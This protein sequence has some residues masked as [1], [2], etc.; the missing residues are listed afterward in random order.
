MRRYVTRS[1]PNACTW[2]MRM[3]VLYIYYSYII[4]WNLKSWVEAMKVSCRASVYV[5]MHWI[6]EPRYASPEPSYAPYHIHPCPSPSFLEFHSSIYST[7]LTNEGTKPCIISMSG[8][9]YFL[10]AFV[11]NM[12]KVV[13]WNVE[14]V[15]TL[16]SL[17]VRYVVMPSGP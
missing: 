3:Y 9:V 13:Y 2:H 1:P 8:T 10:H 11:H 12:E 7:A 4:I 5:W 16:K 6:L 15:V 14:M 17:R